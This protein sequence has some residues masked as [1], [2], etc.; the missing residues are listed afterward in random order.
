M[1]KDL[2]H[3]ARLL[4]HAKGWT[5]VG[6]LSLALGIG[7][8]TVLFSAVNGMLLRTIPVR[9]PGT[10]VRVRYA[11]PNDMRTS[12]RGYGFSGKDPAGQDIQS[13]FSYPMYQRFL[14][15]NRTMTDLVAGAPYDRV[16]V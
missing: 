14:D 11:G 4:L 2:R 5:I 9:D 12:S 6:V 16:N 3:A 7:A 15:E 13:T 8:N 1:L 10:L